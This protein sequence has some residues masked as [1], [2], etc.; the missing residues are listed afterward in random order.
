M[1]RNVVRAPMARAI[2]ARR[3]ARHQWTY[4]LASEAEEVNVDIVFPAA[5][6]RNHSSVIAVA[7][8]G[9]VSMMASDISR[10]RDPCRSVERQ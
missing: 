3:D 10:K 9:R 6:G 8:T 5:A 7:P 2:E 1:A 4:M